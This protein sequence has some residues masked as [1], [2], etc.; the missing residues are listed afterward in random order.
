MMM[1]TEVSIDII[2]KNRRIDFRDSFIFSVKDDKQTVEVRIIGDLTTKTV[3]VDK[4]DL[5]TAIKKLET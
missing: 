2:D 4:Q 5:L 3:Y 1:K